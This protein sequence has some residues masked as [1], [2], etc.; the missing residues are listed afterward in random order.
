MTK[1]LHARRVHVAAAVLAVVT[2]TTGVVTVASASAAA[3]TTTTSSARAAAGWLARQLT[4]S[5]H[6]HYAVTFGGKQYP[7]AGETIDGLLAMDAARASQSAA[8]RI[9]SWLQ[10]NAKSYATGSGA[11]PGH[12]Y[13]GALAKLLLAAEAQRAKPHSFGG[14][15][16][17]RELQSEEQPDGA[18]MNT[19]DT[20]FGEGP[21]D[22]ALALIALSHT[23]SLYDWP[24]PR[25]IAWLVGQQCGDGGFTSATQSTPA[26]T[27]SDVDATAYAA[28]ALLTVHSSAA[29]R[30]LHWLSVHANSDGGFGLSN[31]K[32][33]SNAN[34]TALALQAESQANHTVLVT[35]ALNWLHRH[36]VTCSGPTARRG[37]VVF[38]GSTF[39]QATALRATTQAG[40]AFTRKWLGII[41]NTGAITAAPVLKC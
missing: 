21:I 38:S 10:A 1:A 39:S 28:Q 31:G 23:G 6:D 11:T 4:G 13:P 30:A 5:H 2:A 40:Q 7:D 17:I 9:T 29:A 3:S 24:N 36:Q 33:A 26:S 15:D 35:K 32:A 16:L 34:S 14:L 19:A 12:Y 18:F 41:N 25:A 27:C 8:A 22:Q 20:S 37:A